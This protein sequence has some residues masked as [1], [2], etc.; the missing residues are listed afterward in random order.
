MNART[1]FALSLFAL[2]TNYPLQTT[3]EATEIAGGLDV[4]WF[5]FTGWSHGQVTGGGMLFEDVSA[6]V[7]VM[8]TAVGTFP[9]ETTFNGTRI[10]TGQ[11]TPCRQSFTF[12]FFGVPVDT[13][14]V[15]EVPTLD[16]QER[17]TIAAPGVESYIHESGGIPLITEAN[18]HFSM[19]GVDTRFPP[20]STPGA[21]HGYVL[22]GAQAQ[23]QFSIVVSYD[24]LSPNKFEYLRVGAVVP[25]PSSIALCGFSLMGMA[26]DLRQARCRGQSSASQR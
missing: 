10:T 2:V 12:T 18:G 19:T 20:V 3:V 25:E 15:I 26:V 4:S 14:L 24:T 8:I 16:S 9:F 7:D 21:T 5:D 23:S 22:T 13:Q 17:M 1:V 11:V 6:D